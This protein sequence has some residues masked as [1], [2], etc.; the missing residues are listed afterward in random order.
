MPFCT[1]CGNQEPEGATFCSSCG[2][3][4]GTPS[5]VIPKHPQQNTPPQGVSHPMHPLPLPDLPHQ[6]ELMSEIAENR[7]VIQEPGETSLRNHN[8]APREKPRHWPWRYGRSLALHGVPG[9]MVRGL[10]ILMIVVGGVIGVVKVV[11]YVFP[12]GSKSTMSSPRTTRTATP[13]RPDTLSEFPIPGGNNYL[14]G[15]ITSGP[16]GNLWFTGSNLKD[17]YPWIGRITPAGVIS[18]FPMPPSTGSTPTGIQSTSSLAGMTS[19]P[20]GNLWFRGETLELRADNGQ[21]ISNVY[22]IGRMT[23]AG[24]IS[25]FPIP[26]PT[27]FTSD[28]DTVGGPTVGRDGN[29][30][31][32]LTMNT[33]ETINASSGWPVSTICKVGRM[34]PAGV[35]TEFLV[36]G[37]DTLPAGMTSAC[38]LTAMT[39][40]SDGNLWFDLIN[41]EIDKTSGRL[42]STDNEI[43]R[44]TPTGVIT[45]FPVPSNDDIPTRSP[46][47]TLD[48]ITS[49]PDGNLWFGLISYKIDNTGAT[50][51]F[52]SRIGRITPAGVIT[53]FPLLG[54]EDVVDAE[55]MVPGPDGNLWLTGS[56]KNYPWIGRMTPTGVLTEFPMP[57]DTGAREIMFG[58]DG[59]LWFTVA[60]DIAKDGFGQITPD[61]VITE[62]PV[63][64]S[65]GFTFG[66]DGNLWFLGGGSGGASIERVALVPS[67]TLR[68]DTKAVD[69]AI[70]CL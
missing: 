29:L 40:G 53:E 9:L 68:D 28:T 30:W 4:M 11:P 34:T 38:A 62:F 37:H 18:I 33:I 17:N 50:T 35:I 15:E 27:G 66:P 39:S 8:G 6:Q 42:I 31:F 56:N 24:V 2:H 1:E 43:G 44:I 58:P 60:N 12:R 70:D 5:I 10:L 55:N 20:D 51:A 16:D 57:D 49:G 61:G 54:D 32:D 25:I 67:L 14:D 45:E 41:N 7:A 26:V 59:N 13:L 23:P 19:G 3:P 47:D 22:T 52:G 48:H 65:K 46:Y 36:P 69:N 21:L 64:S 63:P